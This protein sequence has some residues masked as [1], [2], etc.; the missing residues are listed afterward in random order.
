MSVDL[1]YLVEEMDMREVQASVQREID[2]QTMPYD[3]KDSAILELLW[4]DESE[5]YM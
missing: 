5:M 4:D 2:S 1:N 3:A